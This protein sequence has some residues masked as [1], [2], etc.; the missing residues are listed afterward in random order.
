MYDDG[1]I[2]DVH[3]DYDGGPRGRDDARRRSRHMSPV[4]RG[5]DGMYDDDR[6]GPEE[7]YHPHRYDRRSY[8][9]GYRDD[10][11]RARSPAT[12][13]HY[14][15]S[16]SYSPRRDAG[17]PSDTVIIEGLPQSMTADEVCIP[18][19]VSSKPGHVVV[20]SE[21]HILL[22]VASCLSATVLPYS[23]ATT[24]RN[25]PPPPGSILQWTFTGSACFPSCFL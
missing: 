11:C 1:E 7:R 14:A 8:S 5:Y 15:R 12:R 20:T 13:G 19:I 16:R 2:H 6:Y 9:R 24:A 10:E 17:R 4:A 21:S 18:S 22:P 25:H 23:A 3:D